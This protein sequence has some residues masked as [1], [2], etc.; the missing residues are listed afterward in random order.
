MIIN[1]KNKYGE[2]EIE[3]ITEA[4]PV[5]TVLVSM[6]EQVN[7]CFDLETAE[8][9][10]LI[11]DNKKIQIGIDGETKKCYLVYHYTTSLVSICKINRLVY[12]GGIPKEEIEEEYNR[13]KGRYMY[14]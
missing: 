11:T 2:L 5:S 10:A 3:T 4:M 8:K 12:V 13:I 1:Y 9:I 14:F 6:V 7:A